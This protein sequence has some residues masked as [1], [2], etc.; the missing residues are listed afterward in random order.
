MNDGKPDPT[1]LEVEDLS[2]CPIRA[3]VCVAVVWLETGFYMLP[4]E[5]MVNVL[6]EMKH[7]LLQSLKPVLF[8]AQ[9]RWKKLI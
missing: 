3:D 7:Y 1:V 4:M 8:V 6:Q 5:D 9:T 2:Y